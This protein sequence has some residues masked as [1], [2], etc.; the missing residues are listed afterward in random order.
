[1]FAQALMRPIEVDIVTGAGPVDGCT[2][3][4]VC[5]VL[6]TCQV[7]SLALKDAAVGDQFHGV[8]EASVQR[9]GQGTTRLGFGLPQGCA[10]GEGGA[11][12]YALP[13]SVARHGGTP[14]PFLHAGD[15]VGHV[16]IA[17]HDAVVDGLAA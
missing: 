11:H 10:K 7:P 3:G 12:G 2:S 14:R 4:P 9:G 1:M 8:T 6:S 17:G 13:S 15:P 5:L 16:L